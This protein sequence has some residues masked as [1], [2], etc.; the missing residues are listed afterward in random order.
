MYRALVADGE[1]L[2]REALCDMINRV[3]GFEAAHA[4]GSGQRAVALCHGDSVDIAFLSVVMPGISGLEAAKRIH[5]FAPVLPLVLISSLDTFAFAQETVQ[6]NI[7][8][9]VS[10]PVSFTAIQNILLAHKT[11]HPCRSPKLVEKFLEAVTAMDFPRVYAAIGSAAEDIRSR[12]GSEPGRR[13]ELLAHISQRLLAALEEYDWQDKNP[14]PLPVFEQSQ[15]A[16]DSG[17]DLS[18]FHTL[19]EVFRRNCLKAYPMLAKAFEY[20]DLKI[21]EKI[22]LEEIVRHCPASQTHVSRIFKKY[23][24]LSVMDYIHLH[25][26]HLAKSIFSYSGGSSSDVAFD[27]GYT[28]P[29]YFSKVFKKYEGSTVQEYKALLQK[30]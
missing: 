19:D 8:A 12:A 22:G 5:V 9:Y 10:K 15:L 24:N 27:L 18:L 2:M 4:V 26:L 16:V 30:S 25:K 1:P 21:K 29:G 28:E 6:L 7:S 17:V 11:R 14:V 20:M 3:E 23:F 13:H